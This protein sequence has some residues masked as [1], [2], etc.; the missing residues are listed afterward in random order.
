[1][2]DSIYKKSVECL[3]KDLLKHH[4]TLKYLSLYHDNA[5]VNL[6]EDDTD[7]AVLS[8][9]PAGIL[10][11]D[12][13]HYPQAETA[14]FI[15]G[16][17]DRLKYKLLDT[18]TKRNYILRLN[19]NLDLSPYNDRFKITNGNSF[20]FYTCPA[21]DNIHIDGNIDGNSVITDEAAGMIM[22]NGY[23]EEDIKKYFQTGA[24]WFGLKKN[25]KII[26]ICFIYQNY[27]DIW[28]IAGV[29]TLEEERN[30]GYAR[31][32]VSS[33]L[34]YI[35]ERNLIPVYVPDALNVNSIKLALS[36]G[37]N[38]FLLLEHFLLSPL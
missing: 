28:E 32:V 9:M 6:I 25:G 38:K 1:M 23:N 36:L 12:T 2:D 31:I 26:S 37:M 16:T 24:V 7:W 34:K 22:R 11:Y 18:L 3:K 19:E 30:K 17:S 35:L 33:A 14:I 4:P 5:D 21:S 15:N 8:A 29:H 10:S 20:S 27:G 13:A